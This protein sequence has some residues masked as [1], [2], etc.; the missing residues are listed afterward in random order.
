VTDEEMPTCLRTKSH[1]RV[2]D[3]YEIGALEILMRITGSR[4][5]ML[6]CIILMPRR[7]NVILKLGLK[8]G[9]IILEKIARA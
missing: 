9:N 5:G 7:E 6:C 3:P 8:C 4:K 1:P 2:H